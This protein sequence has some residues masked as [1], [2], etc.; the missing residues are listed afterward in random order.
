M[1]KP[2][3]TLELLNALRSTLKPP[4]TFNLIGAKEISERRDIKALGSLFELIENSI[5]DENFDLEKY[6]TK[7]T[8]EMA[9][10]TIRN[11]A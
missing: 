6:V 9:K 10:I 2:Q 3:N 4:T 1:I 7:C 11:N 5:D 8:N